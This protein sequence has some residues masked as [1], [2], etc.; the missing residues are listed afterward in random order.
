MWLLHHLF[1]DDINRDC[2][3]FQE[4]WNNHPISGKGN[5]QTPSVCLISP[6]FR[7]LS[8]EVTVQD[9]RFMGEVKYGRYADDFEGIH[10]EVLE[11]YGNAG[12]SSSATLMED[13]LHT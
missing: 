3:E 11:R 13:K 7:S 2:E 9:M 10:P 12:G 4:Q 1:L 6:R 5:D 8:A